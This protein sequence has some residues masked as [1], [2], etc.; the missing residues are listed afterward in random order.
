VA[1]QFLRDAWA[2]N[3]TVRLTPVDTFE[4]EYLTGTAEK[5]PGDAKTRAVML[6]CPSVLPRSRQF[7]PLYCSVLYCSVRYGAALAPGRCAVRLNCKMCS[8][9]SQV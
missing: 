5:V 8:C 3:P 1:F 6:C 4:S 9:N 2:L 7:A